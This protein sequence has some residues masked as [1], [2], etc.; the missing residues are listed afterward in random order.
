MLC[1]MQSETLISPSIRKEMI[2][3]IVISTGLSD[4]IVAPVYRENFE[5][6]PSRS[7]ERI[8]APP[9]YE[10]QVEVNDPKETET[11]VLDPP[12]NSVPEPI[13]SPFG[14]RRSLVTLFLIAL[15]IGAPVLCMGPW[16]TATHE[17]SSG[18]C[19]TTIT[20][21]EGLFSK[22]YT[23][24][25]ICGDQNGDNRRVIQHETYDSDQNC[26]LLSHRQCAYLRAAQGLSIAVVI[27]RYIID[28]LYM[29]I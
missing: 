25:V 29:Y 6:V 14:S 3:A 18:Y 8:E 21:L 23:S 15:L 26:E 22:T 19:V 27:G 17:V 20:I 2:D 24:T 16:A 13:P 9:H 7:E 5:V 10:I 28:V 4:D 11:C 1:Y 12:P